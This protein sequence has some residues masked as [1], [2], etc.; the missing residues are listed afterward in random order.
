MWGNII[1]IL[2]IV[3]QYNGDI[4]L[5]WHTNK[6]NTFEFKPYKEMHFKLISYLSQMCI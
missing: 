4:V 3:K 5:L 6:L 1:G 2:N